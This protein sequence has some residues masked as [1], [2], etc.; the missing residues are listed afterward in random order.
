MPETISQADFSGG[1][2]RG[3]RAPKNT[4]Y[5]AINALISDEG[6]LLRRGGSTYLTTSDLGSTATGLAT[7]Y[8]SVAQAERVI[9]WSASHFKVVSGA[10]WTNVGASTTEIPPAVAKPASLG[11]MI[12]WPNSTSNRDLVPIYGGSLK[13]AAYSTG[14][15]TVTNG[16]TAVTGVGTSWSTNA[17]VGMLFYSAGLKRYPV[18]SVNSN[19]SITLAE[20]YEGTT[21]AGTGYVLEP[22]S[23]GAFTAVFG[24]MPV[25]SGDPHVG[26]AARRLLLGMGNR[27]GFTEPGDQSTATSSN[28]HEFPSTILGLE[29]MGTTA[30]V[31]CTD[32]V[33]AVSNMALDAVDAF[34]NIQHQVDQV[35][36]DIILW[37]DPGIAA[38][39][40]ALIV[41]AVD[42]VYAFAL[43]ADPVPLTGGPLHSKNPQGIRPLYREY[44]EAGY[45]PGL[46]AIYRGHY[47]LPILDSSNAWVDTLVG[48]L[49]RGPAWVRWAN[50]AAGPAYAAKI[51]TPSRTPKLYGV[52]GQRATDLTGTFDPDATRKDDADGTDHALAVT[53]GDFPLGPGLQKGHVIRVRAQYS[54]VDAG[55]DN[56]S[57]TM[58]WSRGPEG[59]SFIT[60]TNHDSTSPYHAGERDGTGY[61][62]WNVGKSAEY[63][64]FKWSTV[65]A[66]A[67]AT[68]R[69]IELIVRPFGKQ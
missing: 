37:G 63:M 6:E 64:R 15:V 26:V 30:M 23:T 68:L 60:L 50:H 52:S 42:D 14:T 19:T 40:N 67:S 35:S 49:D 2:F 32:G 69:K 4:I 7:W 18:K 39:K 56:P 62:S 10:S 28:Y 5:D 44:V 13:T 55:T 20:P 47:L 31:F 36:K 25:A 29:G 33:W 1:I 45:K 24:F 41:P 48:R 9:G 43:G 38:H 51:G 22:V 59:S 58:Q 16:S 54:L 46:A 65:G 34:G 17:D 12:A 53:F 8:S 66:A 3:R 11:N 21:A 61:A 57:T 27:M